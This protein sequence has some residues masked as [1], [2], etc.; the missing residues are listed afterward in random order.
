MDDW[1]H[2]PDSA[3]RALLSKYSSRRNKMHLLI[4]W[5]HFHKW[6]IDMKWEGEEFESRMLFRFSPDGPWVRLCL[7]R[8]L[9]F[10]FTRII[11]FWKGYILFVGLILSTKSEGYDHSLK[12]PVR[13][14]SLLLRQRAWVQAKSFDEDMLP[15]FKFGDE[16]KKKKKKK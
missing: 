13:K 4:G 12:L 7:K 8:W 11:V 9:T 1:V 2:I 16:K 10:T 15:K 6:Y 14:V 5:T 3:R